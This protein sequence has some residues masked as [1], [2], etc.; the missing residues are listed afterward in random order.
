MTRGLQ[1]AGFH[2]TGVDLYPQPRYVGDVFVQADALEF[3]ATA[4]LLQFD[5]IWASPPCQASSV[6][7]HAPGKHREADLSGPTR[8]A[9]I[10]TGLP[11][12][13]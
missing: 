2:V 1:Q 6:L 13:I 9:L 12:V 4:D 10:K 5:I 8:D 11:Y 3:L 7:K